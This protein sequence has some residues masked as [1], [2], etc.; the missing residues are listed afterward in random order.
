MFDSEESFTM[1]C[2]IV[3]AWLPPLRFFPAATLVGAS[4]ATTVSFC[5][6]ADIAVDCLRDELPAAPSIP[7]AAS[8]AEFVVVVVVVV[9]VAP[10]VAAVLVVLFGVVLVV[11]VLPGF[12]APPPAAELSVYS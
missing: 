11:V 5:P 7:C 12:A 4:V 2:A 8:F 6:F 1:G 3:T 10:A 9:L